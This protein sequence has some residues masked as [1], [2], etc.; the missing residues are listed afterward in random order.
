MDR[1]DQLE[2]RQ[3]D[4]A[5][6]APIVD[7]SPPRRR[8]RL[9]IIAAGTLTGLILGGLVV[10]LVDAP[11]ATGSGDNPAV[12]VF[13]LPGFLAIA[14]TVIGWVVAGLPSVEVVDA[15]VRQRRF[16]RAGRAA[17]TEQGQLPGS[18]VPPRYASS[19]RDRHP[20]G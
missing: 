6:G 7:D 11:R 2:V 18:E 8:R 20:S 3:R 4:A 9:A 12:W 10:L 1:D 5:E 13:G 17:T 19:P 14:G 15:P 16:R